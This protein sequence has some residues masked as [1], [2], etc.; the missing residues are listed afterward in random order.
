M[1]HSYLAL[2]MITEPSLRSMRLVFRPNLKLANKRQS[3]L[4]VYSKNFILLLDDSNRVELRYLTLSNKDG[5]GDGESGDYDQ[6]NNYEYHRD[7][8]EVTRV[9][10]SRDA[11]LGKWNE[12]IVT[13]AS[14]SDSQTN[15]VA[16]LNRI[17]LVTPDK[18]ELDSSK[19]RIG[20]SQNISAEFFVA[21]L[22]DALRNREGAALTEQYR[23]RQS[24]L[25]ERL[26]GGFIGCISE[27][28]LNQRIYNLKSD[29]N[30]DTL[31][32][33]DIGECLSVDIY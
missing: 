3:T 17:V 2:P 22:P 29:L 25:G 10:G 5:V 6:N 18:I 1:G 26:L 7:L 32:G 20:I 30:G 16:G 8:S 11:E 33:F 13:D 21:G 27:F 14:S 28:S 9:I 31:D 19:N 4:L 15:F 12:L 23:S 24:A